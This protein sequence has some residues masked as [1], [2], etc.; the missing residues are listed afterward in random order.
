MKTDLP[1]LWV[2]QGGGGTETLSAIPSC[3]NEMLL[4]G[5]EGIIRVFPV[6]PSNKD[7]KFENL[8]T[9]GAFLVSS[10]RKD[11]IVNYLKIFS[12][13]GRECIIENPWPNKKVRVNVNGV[14]SAV[15]EGVTLIFPTKV[16]D[17]ILLES[18]M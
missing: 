15:M 6:W 7:A 12:E 2:T 18:I 4:Q 10:E 1:N 16:A 5:Y 11:N 13:M 3:I 9:Y 17:E 14:E 8:R